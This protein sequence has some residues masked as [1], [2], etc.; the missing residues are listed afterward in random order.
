MLHQIKGA[1][2]S[3]PVSVI[4]E[5]K[6]MQK[7]HVGF[8]VIVFSVVTGCSSTLPGTSSA[9]YSGIELLPD[10]T[11]KSVNDPQSPPLL[12]NSKFCMLGTSQTRW[13]QHEKS[14][15]ILDCT[16]SRRQT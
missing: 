3:S 14:N 4:A 10:N 8:G 2:I 13:S 16:R 9:T 15:G 11:Y 1:I 6:F 5:E 12:A 7:W